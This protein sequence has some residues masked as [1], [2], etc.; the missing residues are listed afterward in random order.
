M[1]K[2]FVCSLFALAV[3]SPVHG[4]MPVNS[5]NPS[6]D[7]KIRW[8][9]SDEFN[10]HQPDWKKW[11]KQGGLPDTT[12]WKWDNVKNIAVEDGIAELTMRHNSDNESDKGTYFTS[13]ILKSYRTFTYGYFEARI[14]GAALSGSGVCPSFWLYSNFDNDAPEGEVIYCEVDVVELQQYDWYQG[15]QDDVR[16]IDMNL[17]CVVKKNGKRNWRRPKSFAKEQ[18]NKWRAPWD[19]R[20]DFHVYGCEVS[21]SDIIWYIDGKEVAGKPNTLWH[22]PKHVALSLGLRKPFVRFENNR[23]NAIDPKADTEAAAILAEFPVGMLVDYVR[24]WEK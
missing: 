13:G 17:H 11:I 20:E 16:D 7:W 9:T 19:P 10:G 22:R 1:I 8:S 2:P 24:V 3:F 5:S 18:L 15:H 6:S 12:S 23:N 21:R 4:Q 14:K